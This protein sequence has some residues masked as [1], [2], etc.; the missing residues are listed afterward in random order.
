MKRR[1]ERM[2]G[3]VRSVDVGGV[4]AEEDGVM[5][6]FSADVKAA[7]AVRRWVAAKSKP[8]VYRTGQDY[9]HELTAHGRIER[10]TDQRLS[11][12]LLVCRGCH[13]FIGRNPAQAYAKAGW[14]RSSA[15]SSDVAV[16]LSAGGRCSMMRGVEVCDAVAEVP[17]SYLLWGRSRAVPECAARRGALR[18]PFPATGAEKTRHI[19]AW[20][21]QRRQ[22]MSNNK[23]AFDGEAFK[24]LSGQGA[25]CRGGSGGNGATS[26]SLG[27][28]RT[29]VRVVV[30]RTRKG[31]QWAQIA[32]T[33]G[34][35]ISRKRMT[36]SRMRLRAA[37]VR[38]LWWVGW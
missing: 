8:T 33:A 30:T 13:D 11:N 16:L 34:G 32:A 24:A 29:A 2:G 3:V 18:T 28:A 38:P 21:N 25:G 7:A 19:P 12:C 20:E 5:T 31:Y 10:P 22:R 6:G 4:A 14:C 9:H 27:V 1:Y 37:S 23:K 15:A 26:C 36:R 17:E 35:A